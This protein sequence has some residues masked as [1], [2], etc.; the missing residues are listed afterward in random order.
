MEKQQLEK[1]GA[2][3]WKKYGKSR[4]YFNADVL[5]ELIGLSVGTTVSM[6]STQRSTGKFQFQLAGVSP[7]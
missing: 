4:A 6:L 2:S 5:A 7:A 3:I 1:L